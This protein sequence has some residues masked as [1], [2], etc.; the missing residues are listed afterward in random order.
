MSIALGCGGDD[1]RGADAGTTSECGACE[2]PCCDYDQATGMTVEPF[3]PPPT[4]ECGGPPMLDAGGPDAGAEDAGSTDAGGSTDASGQ[5]GGGACDCIGETLDF[6]WT[7]GF[8]IYEDTSSVASCRTYTLARMDRSTSMTTTCTNEVPC[9]EDAVTMAELLAAL[10]HPDVVAAFAAAP[11]TYG[12]DMRP[13]DAP[14][15]SVTQAGRTFL[16]GSP[17]AGSG[18]CTPIPTGVQAL[19]DLLQALAGERLEEEDCSSVFVP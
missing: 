4:Y 12:R 11:V 3:C 14:I 6:G 2:R 5:D 13:V 8:T 10:A 1:P 9:T 17:C 19:V 7:G 18:G 16:V 15:Y